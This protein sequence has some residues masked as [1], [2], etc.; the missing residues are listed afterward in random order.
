[1][2]AGTTWNVSGWP[3]LE[4]IQSETSTFKTTDADF[5]VV[6]GEKSDYRLHPLEST[7]VCI[8]FL[9]YTVHPSY[10]EII[11]MFW[12]KDYNEDKLQTM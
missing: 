3:K 9:Q 2:V 8:E 6:Q 4:F 7:N 11:V 1:M 10:S 5:I 12:S